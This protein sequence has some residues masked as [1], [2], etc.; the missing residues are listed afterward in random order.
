MDR[1]RHLR[2][3][4]RARGDGRAGAGPLRVPRQDP[5]QHPD[6]RAGAGAGNRAQGVGLLLLIRFAQQPFRSSVLVLGHILLAVPYV[7]L[8]VQA[9]L[10]GI[11]RVY[12]EAALSA[13]T[14]C[15]PSAR[16]RCRC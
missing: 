7:V 5:G 3:L 10:I 1:A 2:C 13:P 8:V 4:H 11:K 12:E 16:S 14:G 15:R 6:H 9:R